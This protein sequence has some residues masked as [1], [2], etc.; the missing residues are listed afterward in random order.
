MNNGNDLRVYYKDEHNQFHEIDRVIEKNGTT[1]ATVLFRLQKTINKYSVEKAAY[2]L[3]YG[4]PN[5]GSAKN[6]P[7]NVFLFFD[8]FSRKSLSKKWQTN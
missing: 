5:A 3:V 7:E 1:K 4:N 2:Y 8:D 6:N